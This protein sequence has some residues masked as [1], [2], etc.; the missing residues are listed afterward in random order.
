MILKREHWAL[1]ESFNLEQNSVQ[2][3]GMTDA[4]SE[5]MSHGAIYKTSPETNVVIHIHNKEIF[6]HML[7]F[8]YLKTPEDIPFG[9]PDLAVAIE[10]VVKQRGEADGIF[11]TAGHDEGVVAYGRT[12]E[13]AYD[14]IETV[15]NTLKE[16][17]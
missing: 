13:E 2:A 10:N 7:T 11:V 15:Y 6:E 5:S 4:S 14:H 3:V 8:D 9:T 1:V 16:G 12:L 17:K